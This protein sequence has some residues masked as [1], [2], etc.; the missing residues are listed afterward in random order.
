MKKTKLQLSRETLRN[1]AAS[2]ELQDVAGGINTLPLTHC[3]NSVCNPACFVSV[4]IDCT[5]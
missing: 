3:D 1:L 2:Q 4:K 5:E